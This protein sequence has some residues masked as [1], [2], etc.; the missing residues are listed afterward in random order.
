MTNLPQQAA[1]LP[2]ARVKRTEGMQRARL[3]T[4]MKDV[5]EL[6][7]YQGLNVR[8]AA[9]KIGWEPASAVRA[10]G[11]PHVKD[12]YYQ[13]VREIRSNAAQEAYL[14]INSMANEADS[15][16]VR[17]AANQWIAGVDGIAAV[18]RVEGRMTVSHQFAGFDYGEAM[19]EVV[20]GT[21]D[22]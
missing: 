11:R 13:L 12:A 19:G 14:R 4:Q 21:D 5:L 2:Q 9:T 3:S 20:D 18:K 7:A 17:L 15:E 16:H 22:D 6:M 1:D 10:F 8:N